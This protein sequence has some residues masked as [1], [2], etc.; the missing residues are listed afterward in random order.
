MELAAELLGL[1]KGMLVYDLGSGTGDV[2][3][4]L[5][6]KYK[7]KCVGIEIDP[8]KVL[9][10]KIR[11][12]RA[13]DLRTLIEIERKNFL[14]VDLSKADAIYL[15]LS[16]GTKIMKNLEPKLLRELKEGVKIASY[17]HSFQKWTPEASVRDIKIYSISNLELNV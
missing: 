16:G 3:I 9:L 15:F 1:K 5:A 7:V 6:R 10:S 12:S 14:S 8:L 13:K 4:H 11:I 2:V 17:V